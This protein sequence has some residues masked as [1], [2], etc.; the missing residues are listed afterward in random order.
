MGCDQLAT[1]VSPYLDGE[2]GASDRAALEAHLAGCAGCTEAVA[3]ERGV[4][5]AVREGATRHAAP[6]A[7]RA[8]VS[9]AIAAES[10]GR[11]GQTGGT[12]QWM[13]LAASALV[14]AV[15]ASTTTWQI[16]TQERRDLVGEEILD[17]HVRSLMASHLTDVA[18]SDQ[19]SVK[20]WFNGRLDLSPPVTDFTEQGFP[21]VGGRLDYID[22]RP[23]AALVYR[24]RQHIINLFVMPDAGVTAEPAAASSRQGYNVLRWRDGGMALWAVSDLNPA[25]LRQFEELVRNAK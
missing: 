5:R 6:P 13:R 7:L 21:L 11:S 12:R 9:A 4:I 20:P 8:R 17:S 15:I 10:L 24:H 2:L 23:V 16:A 14:A 25:E 19:H 3:R 18:S 1:L 22:R